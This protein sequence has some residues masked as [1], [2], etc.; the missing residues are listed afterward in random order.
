MKKIALFSALLLSYLAVSAQSLNVQSA[1]TDRNR[2]YLNK[3]KA[4]IDKACLHEDTKNDAKTWYWASLIY[5]Q[6][7]GASKDPKSKYKDLDPEWCEKAYEAARRCSELD[8]DGDYKLGDIFR[9]VGSEFYNR[10]IPLF[11]EHKYAE[12]LALSD[13][14]INV[15]TKAGD[16]DFANDASYIAGLCCKQLKDTE[17]VKKYYLPLTRR[18]RVKADFRSKMPQVYE[19]VYNIYKEAGDTVNAFKTAERYTK[20]LHDDPNSYLMLAQAYIWA[21]N[22]D[23]G[24]EMVTKGVNESKAKLAIDTV[25]KVKAAFE[26]AYTKFLCSA[27]A[28]Y[29]MA[30]DYT[31]AENNFKESSERQ[32]QQFEANYGMG[33]MMYD[34][35]YRKDQQVNTMVNEGKFSDED[36][37]VMD[38]LKEERDAMLKQAIPYFKAAD[39]YVKNLPAEEQGAYR[40][41][42]H[43]CLRTLNACY[44]TLDMLE[45]SKPVQQK[46]KELEAGN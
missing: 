15:L 34:R 31:T 5:T 40:G 9:Y 43:D 25:P 20:V 19:T 37:A 44:V 6:I 28:V 11:N 4:S 23:K 13:K 16:P 14:A 36:I 32:P 35:A 7:G 22:K 41:R 12:A 17:G 8:K 1:I 2:G 39:D 10:S 46:I 3:A 33:S 18:N 45:E 24:I 26:T 38:K 42:L 29:V 27:A 21:N 30:G